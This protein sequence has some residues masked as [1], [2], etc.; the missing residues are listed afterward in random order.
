MSRMLINSPFMLGFDYLEQALDKCKS[1]DSYPPYNIEQ[2]GENMLVIKLAVAGFKEE[3]LQITQEDNHL[4]IVGCKGNPSQKEDVN[5]I[6]IHKGISFRRFTKTFMLADG[7]EPLTSYLEN[8]LLIIEL[9]KERVQKEIKI[10]G[11]NS[12]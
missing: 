12:K 6:Y 4:T 8:G 3:D 7:V 5:I 10:I 1:S 11:I 2:Y 9:K